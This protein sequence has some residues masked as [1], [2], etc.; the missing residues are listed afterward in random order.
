MGF[1]AQRKLF[2]LQFEDQ[3]LEGLDVRVRSISL[4]RLLDLADQAAELEHGGAGALPRVRELLAVFTE[5]LEFWN[6]ENEEGEPT[7]QTLEGLLSHETDLVLDIV[8]DW[9]GAMM[10]VGKGDPL[11]SSSTNGNTFPEPSIPMETLSP[12]LAS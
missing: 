5:R 8:L 6:L 9:F 12:N 2:M 3:A 7:P 10:S 11:V 4:G 1:K